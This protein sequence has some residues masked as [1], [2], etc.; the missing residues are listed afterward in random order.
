MRV[1]HA[2]ERTVEKQCA[3]ELVAALEWS[4]NETLLTEILNWTARNAKEITVFIILQSWDARSNTSVDVRY[5]SGQQ[6]HALSSPSQA[7]IYCM[8]ILQENLVIAG[9]RDKVLRIWDA[10]TGDCV[11]VLEGRDNWIRTVH[12]HGDLIVSGDLGSRVIIKAALEGRQAELTSLTD[13]EI[14]GP[15]ARGFC[16][17]VLGA[18]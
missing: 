12:A 14:Q 6:V 8:M 13:D 7:V 2:I 16:L 10:S 15:S 11:R 18:D 5:L 17:K 9:G 1:Q 4:G 3:K